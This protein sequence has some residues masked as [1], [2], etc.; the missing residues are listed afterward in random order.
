MATTIEQQPAKLVTRNSSMVFVSSSTN[1]TE[2]GFKYLVV[3][4]DFAGNEVAKYYAPKNP[5]DRLIFDLA[6]VVNRQSIV[7][8]DDQNNDGLIFTMPNDANDIFSPADTG[9]QFYEI[10]I[11][12]VY[13]V[14]GVLT[15]F[16]DLTST[17]IYVVD[18][19]TQ[20]RLGI[21]FTFD[22]FFP[23]SSSNIGWLTDR[24]PS[25][26][27]IVF[28]DAIE[29]KATDGDYG[30]IAFLNSDNNAWSTADSIDYRIFDE[31]GQQGQDTIDIA[32]VNGIEPGTTSDYKNWLGYFGYLPGN[33]DSDDSPISSLVRPSAVAG[34]THYRLQFFESGVGVVSKRIV[35]VNAAN[36]CKHQPAA[37]TWQNSVGGWDWFRFDGRTDKAVT[38]QGKTY[39]KP[40]GG[41][42]EATYNY[43]TYDRQKVEFY[44]KNNVRF[45]LRSGAINVDE[46]QLLEKLLRARRVLMNFEGQWLP[47][48][49]V[50][51]SITVLQHKSEIVE[52]SVTVEIAQNEL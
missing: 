4:K 36:P 8:T 22:E 3:V 51:N 1:T 30:A 45:N 29:V 19:S 52:L 5:A 44:I 48:V 50:K 46:Q 32:A 21:G 9:I 41:Y 10:E 47:V 14:A 26:R 43:N 27:N 23:T 37:L 40:M 34:W 42:A 31:N 2:P 12:E 16:P 38:K 25:S 7:D 20:Y 35:V 39:V 24:R 17:T 6:T 18:G 15:E 28:E 33:L 13:E 11:G 49:V